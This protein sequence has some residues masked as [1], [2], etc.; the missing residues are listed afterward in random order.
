MQR[1]LVYVCYMVG[2]VFG[3]VMPANCIANSIS[4]PL[5]PTIRLNAQSI[6]QKINAQVGVYITD[7]D[8]SIDDISKSSANLSANLFVLNESGKD[9]FGFSES[10][11]WFRI[12]ISN[13]SQ[14]MRND[15]LVVRSPF[16][17]WLDFYIRRD[18]PGQ[19]SSSNIWHHEKTGDLFPTKKTENIHRFF[20]FDLPLAPGE[21]ATVYLRAQSIDTLLLPLY[22]EDKESYLLQEQRTQLYL[23]MFYGALGLLVIY[24]F[25]LY[26]RLKDKIL[27][28][29]TGAFSSYLLLQFQLDGFSAMSL[30]GEYPLFDKHLRVITLSVCMV[31]F[32]FLTSEFLELKQYLPIWHRVLKLLALSVSIVAFLSM[33]L[34]Y[35]TSTQVLMF[36]TPLVMLVSIT[37][38]WLSMAYDRRRA[39]MYLFAWGGFVVAALGATIKVFYYLP[40]NLVTDYG[41]HF[42]AYC[43]AIAFSFGMSVRAEDERKARFGLQEKSLQMER[44]SQEEQVLNYQLTM[45]MQKTKLINLKRQLQPHFLFN[46]L[47]MI[48]SY[49]YDDADLADKI[50]TRLSELLRYSLKSTE[51]QKVPVAKELVMVKMYLSIISH[52]FPDRLLTTYD[53]ENA[54][55]ALLM[56]PMLLQPIVENSIVHGIAARSGEGHIHVSMVETDGRLIIKVRD[57]GGKQN[58]NE[59]KHKGTGTGMKNTVEQLR[60]IYGNDF[61]VNMESLD[62]VGT[63]VT[64][65][66][67]AE[68]AKNED[69][70]SSEQQGS[71][72]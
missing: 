24:V 60:C 45:D 43:L 57:D 64:I 68:Q 50:L 34:S 9:G 70:G 56:P 33:F 10:Y 72:I 40:S 6:G 12:N 15:V 44:K 41:L 5:T 52:R 21:H 25:F 28:Y 26:L 46:T 1:I 20:L 18:F 48:S 31:F 8:E 19:L 35:T 53:V 7:K 22:I 16:V 69:T 49:I 47:N 58:P 63:E 54:S 4:E 38:G 27:L 67:P 42:G 71:S 32:S 3:H 13:D 36:L 2:V 29:F 61:S 30:L 55:S 17:D 65:D 51:R 23:G 14:N 37:S 66:L 59:E 62:P 39:L 11:L